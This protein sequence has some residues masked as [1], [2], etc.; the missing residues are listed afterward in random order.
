MPNDSKLTGK[1]FG[2]LILYPEN[3]EINDDLLE[4]LM[5]SDNT[6]GVTISKDDWL[7]H[8]P[9]GDEFTYSWKVPGIKM[10]FNDEMTYDKA[11]EIA[12]Q[13]VTKLKDYSGLKIE[14]VLIDKTRLKF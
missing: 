1:D 4:K 5:P 12:E 14:L 3:L 11:K 13:V 8:Q 9:E 2:F 6:E 10:M 7:N